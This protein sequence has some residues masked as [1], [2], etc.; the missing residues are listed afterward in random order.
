MLPVVLTAHARKRLGDERQ[1]GVGVGDVLRAAK[2][3]PG[4][5]PF[6]TRIRNLTASSG[7]KFDIAAVDRGRKRYVVTVIGK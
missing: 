3:L 2:S 4:R 1:A 5:L 6:T 7:K